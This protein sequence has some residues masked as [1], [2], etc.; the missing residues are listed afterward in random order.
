MTLSLSNAFAAPSP[1]LRIL[2][3]IFGHRRLISYLDPPVS[4]TLLCIVDHLSDADSE[5]I[6]LLMAQQHQL[7][8]TS[9]EW[10]ENWDQLLQ[11]PNLFVQ[12]RPRTRQAMVSTLQSVFTL[13]RDMQ[14]YRRPLMDS[15]FNFWTRL[16]SEKNEGGDGS[17]IWKL[18]G[19]E[20][21]LRAVED[22]IQELFTP[23]DEAPPDISGVTIHMILTAL[24]A[25][26]TYCECDGEVEVSIKPPDAPPISPM[27]PLTPSNT[28]VSSAGSPVFSR[29]ASDT[30]VYTK[31]REQGSN[32]HS[33]L[34]S[35]LSFGTSRHSSANHVPQV[36]SPEDVLLSASP[37]NGIDR[38]PP[39]SSSSSPESIT[40]PN[41]CRG[42]TAATALI[43]VFAQLAFVD[44]VMTPRQSRLSIYVFG[45][46]QRL[47]RAAQCP[48]VRIAVL[49]MLLRLRADRDHRVYLS[50]APEVVDKQIF[51]MARLIGRLRDVSSNGVSN[52]DSR[53]DEIFMERARAKQVFER[54]GRRM[55]RGRGSRTSGTGSRSRSRVPRPVQPITPVIFKPRDQ[56][57]AE[58]DIVPFSLDNSEKGSQ[59]LVTYDPLGPND[60]IVLP[61]SEYMDAIVEILKAERDW[62]VLSYLL[63]HL[64]AQL[65]NKHFWCGPMVR[66]SISKLLLELCQSIMGNTF[67]K[68]ISQDEWPSFSRTRDAIGLAYHT[69]TVLISYRLV[70]D[71]GKRKAL[72]DVFQMGLS[73]R[74]DTVIVC[75]HA[76]TLCAYEMETTIV[77]ELPSILEKLTQIVSNPSMA[78]H[79]LTFLCNLNSLPNIYSNFTDA[80]FKLVFAVALQYLQHHNR[81][82][83]SREMPFS[84]SQ[85]VRIMSYSV[86]YMWFLSLK[87]ADRPQHVKFIVRQLLLAN[88]DEERADVDVSTEVCFDL[89]ARYTYANADPKPAPSLLGDILSNPAE[90][91]S[92]TEGIKEKTWVMGY[93]IVTVRLLAKAGW[94]EVTSR[95]ASGTTKFLVKSENVPLVD[96]GDVNPDLDTIPASLMMDKDSRLLRSILTPSELP[97]PPDLPPPAVS[98][99]FI[100]LLQGTYRY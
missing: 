47:L 41:P 28:V 67:G 33:Q 89:L 19:E 29:M 25:A 13:V 92:N 63:V 2:A 85:H 76:L 26:S 15:V 54:D 78:V 74:G 32:V 45:Q 65:A 10:L 12:T 69:L 88:N 14:G 60:E 71:P 72:V 24:A 51:S 62:E 95:R 38:P 35:L 21:A 49:Q 8:P 77:K 6:P 52:D 34:M 70:L 16:V 4:V 17:A 9:S 68:Y 75:T 55:S 57:W 80:D 53:A 36:S 87:L 27:V 91:A 84:L 42:L 100:F 82:E 56:L 46:I 48:R 81:L 58:P 22:D 1:L 73:G 50:R 11:S 39:E 61:T 44:S 99:M 18:L 86:L 43:E 66:S 23:T 31:E 5:R 98:I 37:R 40:V 59:M 83:T 64:P 3:D 97:L 20:A 7:K 30:H 96:L 79:I 93:S 90:G 94:L